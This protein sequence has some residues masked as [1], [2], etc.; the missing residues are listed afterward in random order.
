MI[1]LDDG[2]L[3]ELFIDFLISLLRIGKYVLGW[4]LYSLFLIK[5]GDEVF[6][7][8]VKKYLS[9]VV[10]VLAPVSIT[11][12]PFLEKFLAGFSLVV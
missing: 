6:E 8:F 3:F 12:K 9:R 4:D 2:K 5:F 11:A 1:F 10:L 7:L